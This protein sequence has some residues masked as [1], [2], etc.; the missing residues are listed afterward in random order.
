MLSAEPLRATPSDDL[1]VRLVQGIGAI[2]A[3][4]W[5][6]CVEGDDPFVRHGFLAALEESGSATRETGWM[7]LHITVVRGDELLACAPLY[8]KSHSYGEYVF[9]WGWAHAY[10][11]AGGK[12]YPKLQLSVPF[13]PVPGP[14]LLVRPDAAP[15]RDVLI[16]GLVSAAHQLEVSSLHVTFCR[17]DEWAALGRGGLMQRTGVQYHWHNRGY[18]DFQDFLDACRSGRRKTMRKER[19]RVR[20]QGVEMEVLSGA[21]I[22][23][24]IWDVFYPFYLRTVDKRWGS[25]Y[26]TRRFFQRL[27]ERMADHVVLVMARHHGRYVGGALNLRSGNA[28]YG[29]IWGC[30]QS[31]DFLHFEAC[32]YSAIEYAI[33]TGLAR[34]EA[35]AQGQHKLHRGYEP[36]PTYSAHWIRD[37]G[38]EDAVRRFVDQERREMALE[39][40]Q[41]KELLPFRQD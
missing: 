27:G 9:D 4:A 37:P 15:A 32:Y 33:R 34:V 14:R 30:R 5:D 41:L 21:E 6:A 36:V 28:L 24:A 20:A 18:R 13:T 19:E 22:T 16:Q 17:E 40:E 38:F 39:R 10:E 29:R 35:G 23:P 12:Y 31:F 2:E 26:L 7:P 1:E 3:A 8:L 25:A 11:R